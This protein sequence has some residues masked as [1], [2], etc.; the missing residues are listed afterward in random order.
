MTDA[1]I[2]IIRLL[3]EINKSL[4]K[5]EKNTDDLYYIKKY[6]DNIKDKVK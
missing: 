3:E 6:V 5:I 1:E 4:K 2:K